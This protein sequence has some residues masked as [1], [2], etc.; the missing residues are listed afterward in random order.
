MPICPSLDI[1]SGERVFLAKSVACRR[2][3]Y[4][5]GRLFLVKCLELSV[6]MPYLEIS[7][8]FGR[9]IARGLVRFLCLAWKICCVA[10]W[11][12]Q[13]N[14]PRIVSVGKMQ[15]SLLCNDSLIFNKLSVSSI[16][17]FFI[18]GCNFCG[19]FCYVNSFLCGFFACCDCLCCCKEFFEER[20]NLQKKNSVCGAELL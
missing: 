13:E 12:V 4:G 18:Y 7:L 11:F 17:L 6:S 16:V 20:L 8:I 15:S 5:P 10:V 3:V 19:A 9:K 14:M 1:K 2:I